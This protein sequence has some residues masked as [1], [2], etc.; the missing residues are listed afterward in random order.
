MKVFSRIAVCVVASSVVLVGCSSDG[1]EVQETP[2]ETVVPSTTTERPQDKY[3]DVESLPNVENTSVNRADPTD[4]AYNFVLLST[5]FIPGDV[6]NPQAASER[7]FPLATQRYQQDHAPVG[8]EGV[9]RIRGWWNQK[10]SDDD[11]VLVVD[12]FVEVMVKPTPVGPEETSV[13]RHIRSTQTPVTA[14]GR[15]LPAR[16]QD[17]E[18]VVVKVEDGWLVDEATYTAVGG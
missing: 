14:S 7:G 3:T 6:F 18:L 2:V 1:E 11:P 12:S 5:T 17:A 13:V 9:A 4:V 8:N 10:T 16:V 15:K